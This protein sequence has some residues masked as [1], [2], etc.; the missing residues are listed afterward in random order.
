[1]ARNRRSTTRLGVL[2][3]VVVVG[4]V[5]PA[6]AI[7]A[8]PPNDSFADATTV[9]TVPQQFEGTIVDATKEVGEPNHAGDPGGHSV[10]FKWTAPSS[11]RRIVETCQG[12]ILH[13]DTVLA[14]Y[15]GGSV[16]AL[17]D[18]GGD[19]R[20]C[21]RD[22]GSYLAFQA[23]A[24]QTYRIAL[25]GAL[26]AVGSYELNV[27]EVAPND[28]F[29]AATA[30]SGSPLRESGVNWGATSEA[31]E[32]AHN[33][34]RAPDMTVWWRWTA[35]ANGGFRVSAG[36]PAAPIGGG[37]TV[38]A[39]YSGSSLGSLVKLG[40]SDNSF[41]AGTP[42]VSFSAAAGTEYRFVIDATGGRDLAM[43]GVTLDVDPDTDVDGFVD[44]S[45]NCPATANPGQTDTDG[46]DAGDACD[47]DDDGDGVADA[48]DNCPLVV[49]PG[50]ADSDDDGMGDACDPFAPPANDDF[51]AAT[52][53][54]DSTFASATGQTNVDATK[55]PGEP[56]HADNPGGRSVWFRWTA[57]TN[58]PTT[59]DTCDGDFDTVIGVYIGTAV[60]G[61]TE[62]ADDDDSC[63]REGGSFAEFVAQAGVT[64]RIAV[65]GYNGDFGTF[66]VYVETEP[67]PPSPP[68][69]PPPPPPSP[70]PPPPPPPPGATA[71]DDRLD[72][73]TG[74][75]RICGLGGS[76]VING[77]AG[78]D[79]LFGDAC[80]VTA[81]AAQVARPAA[82]SADVL[83]GGPG[84]DR[85]YGAE[86]GDTLRG[87][88]G[89][90]TL[91]GG[92]GNDRLTGGRGPDRL[93]GGVGTDTINARD[94]ARDTIVCGPG[95]DT[96]IADKKDRLTG[97]ERVRR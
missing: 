14:V 39:V 22:G 80:G 47:A 77:L 79:V 61:L 57:P 25:D 89:A 37:S 69:P 8:P 2:V 92:R 53:L 62:V 40:S 11:G 96:A 34:F 76:D 86:G 1:M 60:G 66:D 38:L 58:G 24:G 42:R 87:S 71:G 16:S 15:T 9:S 17:T 51:T 30:I 32:P 91:V 46:D 48:S 29:A 50:Q 84:N 10:W 28:A 56:D 88:G 64:Y 95:T 93:V 68:P 45:D 18:V 74:A 33:G 82:K 21:D 19:R 55:E 13:A 94:N 27:R 63:V 26:G 73:T 97:C 67:P 72:G 12:Q 41:S 90:D 44:S 3:T 83:D 85:L 6:S 59:V 35:P 31:G 52:L 20:G 5:M 81:R 43:G 75:D 4:G 65:D 7:A 54:T 78:N 70:P 23:T 49:N 36:S